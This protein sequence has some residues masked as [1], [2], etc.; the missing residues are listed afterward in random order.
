MW[1]YEENVK[2]D[3]FNIKAHFNCNL[4]I[5]EALAKLDEKEAIQVC[6]FQLFFFRI[7]S[8][9]LPCSREHSVVH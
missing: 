3:K 6:L 5:Y 4:W 2:S 9:V 1:F 8:N 7:L